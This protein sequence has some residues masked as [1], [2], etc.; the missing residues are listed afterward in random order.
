MT[1]TTFPPL[2]DALTTLLAELADGAE[3]AD[4]WVLNKTD[5]GL[6]RSLDTLSAEAASTVPPSG[7]ASVA[8]H[9]DHLRYSYNLMNRFVR[10]EMDAFTGADWSESWRRIRVSESEWAARKDELRREVKAWQEVLRTPAP[11]DPFMVTGAIASV[12]HLAYHLGAM[13]QIDRGMGGP[14]DLGTQGTP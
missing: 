14:Q 13:R 12:V 10:G 9:V 4:C 11:L 5:P 2:H 6:L 1:A 7:G 3:A 8:A